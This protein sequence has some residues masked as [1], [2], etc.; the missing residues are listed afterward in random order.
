MPNLID[1]IKDFCDSHDRDIEDYEL[2][3]TAKRI[4]RDDVKSEQDKNKPKSFEENKI[5][6]TKE[7]F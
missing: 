1:R 6:F 2:V 3:E 7:F 4:F 5:R